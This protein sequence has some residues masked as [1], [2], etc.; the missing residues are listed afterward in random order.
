MD[1]ITPA[2][3]DTQEDIVHCFLEHV[4]D[5]MSGTSMAIADFVTRFSTLLT[6][7]GQL[8]PA[9]Q[10]SSELAALFLL[11]SFRNSQTFNFAVVHRDLAS[12]PTIGL[13][14]LRTELLQWAHEVQRH[15]MAPGVLETSTSHRAFSLHQG[16]CICCGKP[17]HAGHECPHRPTALCGKCGRSFSHLTSQ[18]RQS[19]ERARELKAFYSSPAGKVRGIRPPGSSRWEK[20]KISATTTTPSTT[21]ASGVTLAFPRSTHV[22][23]AGSVTNCVSDHRRDGLLFIDSG[24][25][26][27]TVV[28]SPTN[29]ANYIPSVT[30]NVVVTASGDSFPILGSGTLR[31][32]IQAVDGSSAGEQP[33]TLELPNVL[34]VPDL[35][36]ALLSVSHMTQHGF[37][38]AF[39]PTGYIMSTPDGRT[40]QGT[41]SPGGAY[42]VEM[43]ESI[44]SFVRA[45]TAPPQ[46]ISADLAHARLG[47]IGRTR[48]NRLSSASLP[49]TGTLSHMCPSCAVGKLNRTPTM[50]GPHTG[51]ATSSGI[52]VHLDFAGPHFASR[53]GKHRYYAVIVEGADRRVFTMSCISPTSDAA[54]QALQ[55]AFAAFRFNSLRGVRVHVDAAPAHVGTATAMAAFIS[56]NGLHLHVASPGEHATLGIAERHVQ[57]I[58]SMARTMLLAA[59]LPDNLWPFAVQHATWLHNRVPSG[60]DGLAPL[61]RA[62]GEIF[63]LRL[64]RIFGCACWSRVQT[65]GPRLSPR[66]RP[67]I[68]LGSSEADTYGTHTI[69]SL[70]SQR[71]GKSRSV[72]FDESDFP[73]KDVPAG[74]HPRGQVSP[75]AGAGLTEQHLP[76]E[77]GVSTVSPA[78]PAPVFQARESSPVP[79]P[80]ETVAS[81]A[82]PPVITS[83]PGRYHTEDVAS[84]PPL[85][86]LLTPPV[87]STN[88]G[89]VEALHHAETA[90]TSSPSHEA[91]AS[92]PAAHLAPEQ[93]V[94]SQQVDLPES[95]QPTL[96][97]K[98]APRRSQRFRRNVSI[99]NLTGQSG[100]QANHSYPNRTASTSAPGANTTN[101]IT[102]SDAQTTNA[103]VHA[104]EST[105]DEL[106]HQQATV[107]KPATTTLEQSTTARSVSNHGPPKGPAPIY[108]DSNGEPIT[109][110]RTYKEY[111]ALPHSAQLRWGKAMGLEIDQLIAMGTF[112][113]VSADDPTVKNVTPLPTRWVWRVKSASTTVPSGKLKARVVCKGYMEQGLDLQNNRSPTCSA[114]TIRAMHSLGVSLGHV[115]TLID[116]KSAFL[117]AEL[118][119]SEVYVIKLPEGINIP[120]NK[121]A[122]L[123]RGLYGLASSPKR[124]NK[125]LSGVL[126]E[127]GFKVSPFDEC[128]FTLQDGT[129]V[130]THVDD[131]CLYS[132]KDRSDNFVRY[133][134]TKFEI[135]IEKESTYLSIAIADQQDGSVV[136]SQKRAVDQ[137]VADFD[138]G[139]KHVLKLGSAPVVKRSVPAFISTV[140]GE[141]TLQAP[142]YRELV[143]RLLYLATS[144]RPDISNAVRLAGSFSAN[145]TDEHFNFVLRIL[146]Y[147]ASTPD[148][149]LK[150]SPLDIDKLQIVA[151]SDAS[152]ATSPDMKSTTG[153]VTT[154]SDGATSNVVSYKSNTQSI[155]ADS[156]SYAE[157]IAAVDCAKDVVWLQYLLD[158]MGIATRKPAAIY[159][160]ASSA[161]TYFEKSGGSASRTRHYA[162]RLHQLQE[163]VNDGMIELRH[164]DGA[165][166]VADALTKPLTGPDH[167][168]LLSTITHGMNQLPAVGSVLV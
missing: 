32:T 71:I 2:T 139:A 66:A 75:P 54:V 15:N 104:L 86:Q 103:E 166:N 87:A 35:D 43:V 22:I 105:S 81:P 131:L 119:E 80:S 63:D 12:R 9:F 155:V 133:L 106:R 55:G 36:D 122:R 125:L 146:R 65:V 88:S 149:G 20:P 74:H 167:Y 109:E 113:L 138:I 29:L 67:G 123:R 145:S 111:L 3:V 97:D 85:A 102:T 7:M 98:P 162:I 91:G 46:A 62:S 58:G 124:F 158:N 157:V 14:D 96:D 101:Q 37:T 30:R 76:Y 41:A 118:D 159:L 38:F 108:L 164:V 45:V 92:L 152:L 163:W 148:F 100:Q 25:S 83:E 57:T 135:T 129:M 53:Y 50:A 78:T 114:D 4:M 143:G 95:V 10:M 72:I 126:N 39:T 153:Y 128:L 89:A 156:S 48:L 21:S 59:G 19:E 23:H 137:L 69:L 24:C 112:V 116:V 84:G 27:R 117:L 16:P 79:V 93:F 6:N 147:V 132:S 44:Q 144:T 160:D 141:D 34:F 47:H 26:G 82:S 42:R 33:L 165:N 52:E 110:I 121:V 64:T 154:L 142:R 68:Y 8:G 61:T 18:C 51:R 120:A 77:A 73:Y 127:Y 94:L 56:S 107:V 168:R 150:I 11:T 1:L 5:G 40:I 70:D 151:Y 99:W 17:K 60:K 28:N 13:T 161:I 130:A 134:K 31:V 90:A 136:L 140:A 115:R 49:I